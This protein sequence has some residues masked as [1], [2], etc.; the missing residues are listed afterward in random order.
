MRKGEKKMEEEKKEISG[1]EEAEK[2]LVEIFSEE[3]TSKGE[4][5]EENN[6][7]YEVH[8]SKKNSNQKGTGGKKMGIIVLGV[9]VLIVVVIGIIAI[10]SNK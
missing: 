4:N 3:A 5:L 9:I 1:I 2:N 7:D 10:I 6:S 8:E